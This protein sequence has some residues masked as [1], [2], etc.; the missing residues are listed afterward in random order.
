MNML[1]FLDVGNQFTFST[2]KKGTK[3]LIT[4]AR[5]GEPIKLNAFEPVSEES[6]SALPYQEFSDP[7]ILYR[8]PSFDL[9]SNILKQ[10]STDE[11]SDIMR[12]K[13]I[14]EILQEEYKP[15]TYTD[16]EYEDAPEDAQESFDTTPYSQKV[17]FK[18][19]NNAF[20]KVAEKNPDILHYRKILTQLADAESNFRSSIKNPNA[21]AYGYF[22]LMQGETQNKVWNNIEE[23]SG[24]STEDFLKDPEAQ[25]E[26]AY[27]MLKIFENSFSDEDYEKAE[28]LGITKFGMLG[29]AWLGGPGG[30]RKVLNG[31]GNPSDKK[32][33][34]NGKQG[35]TV[36]TYMQIFS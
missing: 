11:Y 18:A 14:G 4:K 25:I 23:Y 26:A 13:S 1:D 19:F 15:E 31:K 22:Q 21:P 8:F 35:S 17:G 34:K 2:N 24:L 28:Q 3:R 9:I 16:S 32:W 27:K 7:S 12:C 33:S 6:T 36:L 20:D 30:V 5:N 10:D 29:G